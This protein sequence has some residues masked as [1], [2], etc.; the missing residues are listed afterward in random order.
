M[1]DVSMSL[2]TVLPNP[3]DDELVAI[4]SAL[5]LLWPRP[6]AVVASSPATKPSAAWRFS[7]RWW[8]D[9]VGRT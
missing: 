4:V 9:R 6:V 3:S 8:S 7:G 5:E 1:T 2:S